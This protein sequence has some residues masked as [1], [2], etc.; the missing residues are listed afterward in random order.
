MTDTVSSRVDEFLARINEKEQQVGAFIEFFP[1]EA[2]RKAKELDARSKAGKKTGKLAGLVVA[3]KNNIAVKGRRMTCASKI[4][5]N[6]VAPYSATVVER[7]LAEDAII[8]GT[9]NMDEFA[10]GSDTTHSALKPTR[11]PVDLERVPGGSSGGSAAAVAAGF[12]D[13]ALGSDT[14]GSIRCPASFCGV[15]GFKPTYG[16]VSRYGLAD[17]AMSFDQIG[18]IAKTA[19]D[20]EK[21]L[22]AIAGDDPRDPVTKGM[23]FKKTAAKPGTGVLGVPKEFF[24]GCDK[25]VEAVVRKKIAELEGRGWHVKETSIPLLSYALPVYYL[26]VYAEFSSAM[27]KYDGLKYGFPWKPGLDL[28]EAVSD[29]RSRA[30]GKEVKRRILLGTYITTKEYREAW[31][32]KTLRAREL[33]KREVENALKEFDLL[34]GPAMPL[35]P[36]RF[37]EKAKPL[38]LYLADILT[39]PANICGLPAGV[40]KAG[41]AQGLPVGIQFMGG[42][43]E[44]AKVLAAMKAA[45]SVQ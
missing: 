9:T 28:T 37:G 18:P 6:Y 34:V 45:E 27:Q 3:V 15:A 30:F 44:D 25:K 35:L 4:L 36:W 1:D 33:L 32:T 8:I 24:D 40:V 41:E 29:A 7:M 42:A 11:N 12:C 26:L 2:R 31:Y 14:G 23:L 21:I 19:A 13:F 5:E 43:S 20:A 39:V 17:L 38:E 10:C 22:E 16:L